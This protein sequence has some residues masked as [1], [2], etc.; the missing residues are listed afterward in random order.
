MS[1]FGT[2]IDV[3]NAT[4]SSSS[5]FPSV[6]LTGRSASG[7]RRAELQLLVFR[8]GRFVDK[9]IFELVDFS[10]R[11]VDFGGGFPIAVLRVRMKS[12]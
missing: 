11:P 3:L 5:K 7:L 9:E 8:L 2:G 4:G 6:L 1:L 12:S 10:I